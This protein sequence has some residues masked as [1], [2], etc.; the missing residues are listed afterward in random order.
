MSCFHVLSWPPGLFF[1]YENVLVFK[2]LLG[3]ISSTEKYRLTKKEDEEENRIKRKKTKDIR[4]STGRDYFSKMSSSCIRTKLTVCT[5]Y[6][7]IKLYGH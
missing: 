5:K 3:K 1:Y 4:R 2:K 6:L 7:L